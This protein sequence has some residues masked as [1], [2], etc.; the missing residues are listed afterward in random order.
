MVY[1]FNLVVYMFVS[2]VSALFDTGN[3][4]IIAM[5]NI[6]VVVVLYTTRAAVIS[7]ACIV[8]YGSDK[9]ALKF[10]AIIRSSPHDC[11]LIATITISMVE[12]L[13]GVQEIPP[14]P[15]CHELVRILYNLKHIVRTLY[16][17][18]PVLS[19]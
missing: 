8:T 2:V 17:L 18:S 11:L 16:R 3:Y 10:P 12:A 13:L 7:P 19:A 14:L 4:G 9:F 15:P 5:V 1:L 6:P